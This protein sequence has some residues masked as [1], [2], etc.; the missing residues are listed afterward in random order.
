MR[1]GSQ[2]G[3]VTASTPPGRST[4]ATSSMARWSSRM[5]SNTSAAMTRSNEP[6]AN[7]SRVASPDT[8]ALPASGGASPSA[9]IAPHSPATAAS[10]L[11]SRSK[12]TTRAPRR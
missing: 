10:S 12:G 2:A 3:T 9:R 8:A 6:S 4:R 7:G 5:C 11:R 1:S